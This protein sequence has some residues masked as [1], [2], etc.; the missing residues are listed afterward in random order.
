MIEYIR[1]RILG[2]APKGKKRSHEWRECRNRFIRR[3]PE[4]A[5]CGGTKKL[6]V[7]HVI[8]FHDAPELELKHWNLMTLCR[9]KKYGISCHQLVGHIGNYRDINPKARS[10]ASEMKEYLKPRRADDVNKDY[11]QRGKASS[12]E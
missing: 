6:E 4:C 9:R 11:C 7:H 3:F 10:M 8:P 1:D 5:A 2:K 12:R